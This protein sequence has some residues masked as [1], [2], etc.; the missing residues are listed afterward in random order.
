[1]VILVGIMLYKNPL[2]LRVSPSFSE[3]TCGMIQVWT[4]DRRIIAGWHIQALQVLIS[5]VA[6]GDIPN[7]QHISI[8]YES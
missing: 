4:E 8:R 6:S 1:M 2:E 3:N 5:H 7:P